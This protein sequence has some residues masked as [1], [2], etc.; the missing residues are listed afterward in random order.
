MSALA[1]RVEEVRTLQQAAAGP[2]VVICH[3]GMRS[4]QCAQFL[5]N[6][7]FDHLINLSGGI[8]AWSARVD[9]SVPQY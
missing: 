3:H 6:Q 7:G 2:I 8:D 4:M 5:S 1:S 9:P